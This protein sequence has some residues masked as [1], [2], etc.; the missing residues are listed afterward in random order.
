[1][2]PYVETACGQ[3]RGDVVREQHRTRMLDGNAQRFHLA[4][5]ERQDPGEHSECG[6]CRSAS[7]GVAP[8]ESRPAQRVRAMAR[9]LSPNDGRQEKAPEI[10]QKVETPEFIQMDDRTRIAHDRWRHRLS[11]LHEVPIGRPPS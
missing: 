2:D 1:M 7:C 3:P 6:R 8:G 4:V 11:R 5:M 9:Y 10:V